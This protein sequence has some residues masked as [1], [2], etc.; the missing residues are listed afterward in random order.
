MK[1]NYKVFQKLNREP[2]I[3][4][5]IKG[6]NYKIFLS[7]ESEKNNIL[8]NQVTSIFTSSNDEY[9][10][11]VDKSAYE[12]KMNKLYF[13]KELNEIRINFVEKVTKLQRCSLFFVMIP[14]SIILIVAV[15]VILALNNKLK[16][17][18]DQSGSIYL[19]ASLMA[20]VFSTSISIN[21]FIK[22]KVTKYSE[23]MEKGIENALGTE[24]LNE[25][26]KSMEE[27]NQLKN[28]LASEEL[29]KIDD[30]KK[31]S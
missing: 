26:S 31:T 19:I 12:Y 17:A 7:T 22:F 10:V 2:D 14:I 11:L 15:S 25:L 16:A 3:I 18:G 27:Y 4:Q 21:K 5:D 8:K 9:R 20:L 1:V 29:N 6:K 23:E 28:N 13:E 24:R 30:N